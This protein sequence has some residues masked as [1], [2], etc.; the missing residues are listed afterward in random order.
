MAEILYFI[1]KLSNFL[2]LTWRL[3]G[4]YMKILV[5]RNSEYAVMSNDFLLLC[6][7]VIRM[8]KMLVLPNKFS[9]ILF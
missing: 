2:F 3:Y 5:F 1:D 8:A 6:Q 4:R 7:Y 9:R